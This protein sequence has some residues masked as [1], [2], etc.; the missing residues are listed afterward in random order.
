LVKAGYSSAWISFVPLELV[1][2]VPYEYEISKLLYFV[3]RVSPTR[4]DEAQDDEER[5]G[6]AAARA[7]SLAPAGASRREFL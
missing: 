3:N 4:D 2:L 6:D 5:A 7:G 1:A